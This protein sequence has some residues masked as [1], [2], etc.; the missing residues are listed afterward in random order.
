MYFED[1][2]QAKTKYEIAVTAPDS[3]QARITV[4][5]NKSE[6]F[7]NKMYFKDNNGRFLQYSGVRGIK[8]LPSTKMFL[9]PA[10]SIGRVNHEGF[11]AEHSIKTDLMIDDLIIWNKMLTKEDIKKLRTTELS[12]YE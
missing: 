9:D 7:N 12:N 5:Y 8:L 10:V 3:D 4:V 1:G 6:P 2:I 11:D